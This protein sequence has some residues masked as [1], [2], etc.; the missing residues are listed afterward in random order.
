[1]K[2][3]TKY[4]DALTF[5]TTHHFL[6]KNIRKTSGIP[7]IVH[8]VRIA[9]ILRAVGFNEYKDEEIMIAA[10]FHDLLEDTKLESDDLEQIYGAK[11]T[12]IVNELTKPEDGDKEKWLKTFE[13][14]SNEA[15]IIKIADRI[16]NLL[17]AKG[18]AKE[19]IKNYAEQAKLIVKHC[20]TAH[21]ELTKKLEEI[22]DN[23]LI[24]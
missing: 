4:W 6:N 13:T 18:W 7:Y 23:I 8:P 2:D 12:S 1:M 5:A 14:A 17:D 15:K 21:L 9:S 19:R 3:F 20:G 24:Q 16:D 10:L 22:I 11:I